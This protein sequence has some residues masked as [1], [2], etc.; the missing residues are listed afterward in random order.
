ME[1]DPSLN[2]SLNIAFDF[3]YNLCNLDSEILASLLASEKA[4]EDFAKLDTEITDFFE[5]EEQEYSN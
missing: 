5:S 2:K 3:G 1:N 4:K